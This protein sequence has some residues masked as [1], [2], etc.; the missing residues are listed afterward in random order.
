ML[1]RLTDPAARARAG[2]QKQRGR[3][4]RL[5]QRERAAVAMNWHVGNALLGTLAVALSGVRS[6]WVHLRS[7]G[8]WDVTVLQ[9]RQLRRIWNNTL[10]RSLAAHMKLAWRAAGV[11]TS[12]PQSAAR[13]TGVDPGPLGHA[14]EN[15]AGDF[16]LAA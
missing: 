14:P 11:I 1:R 9:V 4:A 10:F 12:D 15:A 16:R 6:Q 2:A 7:S 5:K 13:A 8:F 3:K